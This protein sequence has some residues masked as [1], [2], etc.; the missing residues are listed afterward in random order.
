MRR[1]MKLLAFD[2]GASSGRAMLGFFD[3][4][5]LTLEEIHRFTN[6]PVQIGG[7]LYWDILR[8]FHELKR[9]IAL[10]VKKGHRDIAAMAIDT[11]GVDF[12]L[13]D[14]GGRL[15]GNPYHYRDK[16]TDGIM[17]EV[18]RLIPP[19][20][21]YLKTGIQLMKLNTIFQLYSMKLGGLPIFR[22]ARTMLPTPDLLNYFLTGE[23][24]AEYSI[25]T[26]TQLLDPVKREWSKEI[27]G[28]LGLPSG[29]FPPISATG[30]V[31][32][33]LTP[34]IAR[35]LGIGEIPVIAAASHDT[36]SAIASVPAE[37]EDFAYISSGTW[38]LMGVE[39]DRPILN[40]KSYR[41]AF[42]NE[43][44]VGGKI[45]FLKNIPGLW[46]IQECKRQWEREGENTS[47]AELEEMA[48]RSEPFEA[49]IDPEHEDFLPPGDLPSR[50]REYCAGTNQPV[51]RSKGETVRCIEQS[52]AMKYRMTMDS[53]EEI[54]GKK[55]PAI[56]I[57][58]GG[59]KDGLLCRL[60]ADAT[61]RRTVTGPVEATSVGNL[62]VQ[63]MALGELDNLS[64]LRQ[65]V[66]ESFPTT[67]YEPE[68]TA[69]WD[70]AY[71]RFRKLV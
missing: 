22:E 70:A 46:L 32:G 35:E 48:V 8:L 40:E 61:G 57:V 24:A 12:G 20:E 3:G 51:P 71:E 34:D 18:F 25:A 69:G 50:I 38:S 64:E 65:V 53:L 33:R 49:F 56:H 9:G 31:V 11:W 67:V 1:P 37:G 47:F 6:E 4:N 15:L 2:L 21:L 30:S 39:T 63:A 23:K 7:S 44:G 68:D 54:T 36:Q 42:T 19:E 13:L 27:T 28:R 59:I 60:T 62:L 29:I 52:L 58:G 10:C 5:R 43:G 26:T 55:L 66:R 14:E 17:E 16:N 45:T 41:L